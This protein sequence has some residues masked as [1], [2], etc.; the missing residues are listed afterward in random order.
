[1][2][3]CKNGENYPIIITKYSFLTVP[4]SSSCNCLAQASKL[5]TNKVCFGISRI[6]PLSRGYVLSFASCC[7]QQPIHLLKSCVFMI[8]L[9]INVVFIENV[10]HRMAWILCKQTKLTNLNELHHYKHMQTFW[11]RDKRQIHK[12]YFCYFSAIVSLLVHTLERGFNE[13]TQNMLLLWNKEKIFTAKTNKSWCR[14]A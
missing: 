11:S 13:H 7:S 5:S 8:Y 1:M 14:T 2:F 10:I 6:L 9:K 12:K 3:L 4:L